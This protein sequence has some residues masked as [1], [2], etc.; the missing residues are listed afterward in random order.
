MSNQSIDILTQL[1]STAE[2][3]ES[4]RFYKYVME[5]NPI[6]LILSQERGG[7]LIVDI[8]GPND[9]DIRSASTL[10]RL[11]CSDEPISLKNLPAIFV[12]PGISSSWKDG[13]INIREKVNNFLDS[14]IEI[15]EGKNGEDEVNQMPLRREI[16]DTF[17][18]GKIFHLKDEV[19]RK[20]FKQWESDSIY[21]GLISTEMNAILRFLCIAI[22]QLS[23]LSKKEISVK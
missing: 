22:S 1:I 10:I 23:E 7:P 3:L 11:F 8:F 20:R 18:N 19:K 21:F 17:M 16:L 14:R 6:S 15:Y 2:E 5:G 12:D 4:S 9:D 13:L